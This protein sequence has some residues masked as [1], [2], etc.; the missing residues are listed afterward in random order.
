VGAKSRQFF[1]GISSS[2][3]DDKTKKVKKTREKLVSKLNGHFWTVG[4]MV[5]VDY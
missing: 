1:K 2:R 3:N 4:F 5:Q